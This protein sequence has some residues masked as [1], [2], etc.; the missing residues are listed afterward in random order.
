ML[1]CRLLAKNI[2]GHQGS[3]ICDMPDKHVPGLTQRLKMLQ[4]SMPIWTGCDATAATA[5]MLAIQADKKAVIWHRQPVFS[6]VGA[7]LEAWL[8]QCPDV[9]L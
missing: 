2:Q 6:C 9:G 1:S 5:T 4:W 7:S 3:A 8:T